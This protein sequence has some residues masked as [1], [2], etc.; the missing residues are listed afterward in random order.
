[1]AFIVVLS[2]CPA[3]WNCEKSLLAFSPLF[4]ESDFTAV[5]HYDFMTNILENVF[6]KTWDNVVCLSGD[7]CSTNKALATLA[8]KPLVGCFAHRFN[9][10]VQTYLETHNAVLEQV[11][12]FSRYDSL[13][14]RQCFLLLFRYT[15]YMSSCEL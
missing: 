8:G 6:G 7:N 2:N 13:R 1:V 9:I 11:Y 4:D 3:Q 15:L 5:P 12:A 14:L 10:E